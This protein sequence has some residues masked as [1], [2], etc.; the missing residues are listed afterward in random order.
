M[1][2]KKENEKIPKNCE[3]E[4]DEYLDGWKRARADLINYKKEESHR[5]EQ[6]IKFGTEDIIHDLLTVMDSFDR[7]ENAGDQ[8]VEMIKSQLEGILK[9]N[10]CIPIDALNQPFNP[11]FHEAVEEIASDAAP[12]MIL[13]EVLRGWTFHDRVI[14]PTQVKIAKEQH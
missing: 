9:K 4:R 3:E 14:R 2:K 12:G 11:A 13:E 6:A 10:N 5:I 1:S 8:G 7:A